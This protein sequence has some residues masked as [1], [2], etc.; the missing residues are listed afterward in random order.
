M[1][2]I[3][4]LIKNRVFGLIDKEVA[5][6]LTALDAGKIIDEHKNIR[7][8]EYIQSYLKL[9]LDDSD[10]QWN[11]FLVRYCLIKQK[12]S[13]YDRSFGSIVVILFLLYSTVVGCRLLLFGADGWIASYKDTFSYVLTYLPFYVFL[14]FYILPFVITYYSLRQEVSLR[15]ILF[16]HI[17]LVSWQ[18]MLFFF[19]FA[20]A[21]YICMKYSMF[22]LSTKLK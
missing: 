7:V 2:R 3:K 16:K 22:G 1:F 11:R 18:R 20:A 10:P 6:A 17:K 4:N 8:K 21:L 19:V 14:E 15:Y 12:V 9:P 13:G 5:E